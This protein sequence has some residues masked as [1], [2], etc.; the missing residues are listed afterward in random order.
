MI[1]EM[2]KLRDGRI[3]RILA[4]SSTRVKV[5]RR[6]EKEEYRRKNRANGL[7]KEVCAVVDYAI[8]VL[9]VR[10]HDCTR[11]F[12]KIVS[13]WS[14]DCA[15]FPTTTGTISGVVEGRTG[16]RVFPDLVV[17]HQLIVD[18]K[19]ID[20]ITDH[21]RGQM[22]NYLRITAL[23]VW[24]HPEFQAP[25]SGVGASHANQRTGIRRRDKRIDL[26]VA[27]SI[28]VHSRLFVVNS[29]PIV[30]PDDRSSG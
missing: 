29:D 25:A 11:R 14:F 1:S 26:V 24:D 21:E 16:R 6:S 4:R 19:T 17:Q 12:M 9:N 2:L 27:H 15:V 30:C 3:L 23:P 20:R 22:L 5:A 7:H 10:G 13:A 28:S 8:E 18:T